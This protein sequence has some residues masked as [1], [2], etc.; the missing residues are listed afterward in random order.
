MLTIKCSKCKNKLFKYKKIGKGKVLSCW[1][2]K[3][4]RVYDTTVE[5]KLLKCG[6]CGNTIGE[7]K[8]KK[9]DMISS[10]FTYTGTKI[11]K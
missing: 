5:N 8:D 9:V 4:T 10:S 3:I 1:K 2:S 7:V 11:E 6:D